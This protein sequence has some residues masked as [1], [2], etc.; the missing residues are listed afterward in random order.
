M[1]FYD[2]TSAPPVERNAPPGS[3]KISDGS[4]WR[5]WA[6]IGAYSDAELEAILVY[7]RAAY[8]RAVN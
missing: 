3:V 7:L 8:L 1:L 6:V 4:N 5:H 2:L